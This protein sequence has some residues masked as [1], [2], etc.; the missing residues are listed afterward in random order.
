MNTNPN[1]PQNFQQPALPIK[2][3]P[4]L[5]PETTTLSNNSS[6]DKEEIPK[7]E[8]IRPDEFEDKVRE[9]LQDARDSK[10]KEL[11]DYTNYT[12]EQMITYA[13]LILGLF[14]LFIN[15]F[16]GGLVLGMVSGYYFADNIIYY[17]RN[18]GKILGG[19]D[20]LRYITL[21]ALLLGLF[22]AV[23]GIFIGAAIVAAF[24]Q[25]IEGKTHDN[26]LNDTIEPKDREKDE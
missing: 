24:K 21:T 19:H 3:E 16:F 4:L 10:M 11:Y 17:L 13:L 7:K 9:N 23:P 14:L 26:K 18:I 25:V 1:D 12:P 8:E 15:N 2:E 20:H 5:I 22:I 6:I